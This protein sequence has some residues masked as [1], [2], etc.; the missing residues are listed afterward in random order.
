MSST[1]GS[2]PSNRRP[3]LEGEGGETEMGRERGEKE[4]EGERK[5]KGRERGDREGERKGEV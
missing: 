1:M 4:R 2:V 3:I 5:G